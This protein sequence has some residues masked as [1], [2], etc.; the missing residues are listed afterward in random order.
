[1]NILKRQLALLL[2]LAMTLT[3]LPEEELLLGEKMSVTNLLIER[4][5]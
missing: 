1:M 5:N 3:M 2:V 4:G